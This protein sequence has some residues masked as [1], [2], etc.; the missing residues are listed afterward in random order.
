[1]MK[2]IKVLFLHGME[3]TPEGTK[4]TFLRERGLRVIAPSLPKDNFELSL[5]R[6]TAA[7]RAFEPDYVVG[8]SRGGAIAAALHTGKTPKILIAPAVTKFCVTTPN[9]TAKKTIILH[10]KEDDIVDYEDSVEL[11][12]NHGCTLIPIGT[13]HRM[14]DP[15][16]LEAIYNIIVPPGVKI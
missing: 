14:S 5:A 4:P 6:A 10:C 11:A 1:M 7:F 8:S 2:D 3:G 12:Q 9:I 16:T 15:E 13:N